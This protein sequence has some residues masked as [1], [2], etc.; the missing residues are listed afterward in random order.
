MIYIWVYF[1]AITNDL[2]IEINSLGWWLII[3]SW[4]AWWT[5]GAAL[6]AIF[7]P[8]SFNA[9]E[10][11]E[12]SHLFKLQQNE[13]YKHYFLPQS[14]TK[15]SKYNEKALMATFQRF[16]WAISFWIADNRLII[17]LKSGLSAG[18]SLQHCSINL[19]QCQV[20]R[21]KGQTKFTKG[22]APTIMVLGGNGTR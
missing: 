13:H 20:D 7:L 22:K 9:L 3:A 18:F 2:A 12:R 19:H 11:L 15:Y 8:H 10:T 6:I 16:L 1:L 17:T 21:Q 5:G 4:W 14:I